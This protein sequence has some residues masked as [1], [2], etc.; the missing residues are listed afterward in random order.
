MSE[1]KV[2]T[3]DPMQFLNATP[4]AYTAT[5]AAKVQPDLPDP[6]AHDAFT[7][8]SHRLEPDPAELWRESRPHVRLD[9]GVL[10]VDDSTLDKPHGKSIQLD[11]RHWSGKH[12]AVVAGINLVTLFWTDGDRNV[13]CDYRLYDKAD[14]LTENGHFA[15]M[16]A[17]AHAR[18]S[19]PQCVA[20]DGWYGS[21]DDLKSVGSLG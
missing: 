16:V 13:P 3:D 4:R 15:A 9:D 18:G 11:T 10:V 12:H 1:P 7:R 14:G 2:H 19:R 17:D 8:L 5:E 21:L 20:F 6:P